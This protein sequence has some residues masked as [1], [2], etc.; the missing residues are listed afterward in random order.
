MKI[1]VLGTGQVGTTLGAPLLSRGHAVKY[2][3]RDPAQQKV[4]DIVKKQEGAT[5]GT[6]PE[7]LGWAD[8]FLLVVPG[9]CAMLAA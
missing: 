1:G 9:K 3:S 6:W 8:A 2:A 5:A 4:R 7:T